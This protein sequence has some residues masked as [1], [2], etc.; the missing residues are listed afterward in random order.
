MTAVNALGYP[1]LEPSVP[2]P[3]DIEISQQISG[4]GN[5]GLLPIRDIAK[6]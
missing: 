5:V 4:K 2:V 1:V 6:Q 3:S